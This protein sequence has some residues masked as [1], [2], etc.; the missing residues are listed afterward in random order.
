ME[1]SQI[2]A[3][4]NYLPHVL[5]P[6]FFPPSSSSSSSSHPSPHQLKISLKKLEGGQS[7]PTFLLTILRP[8]NTNTHTHKPNRL[9]LRKKPALVKVAS[10]HAIEREYRVLKALQ[11]SAV[12]VP[13]VYH[14]CED[15]DIIGM[16]VCM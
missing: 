2:T 15:A 14:L 9:V 10:A 4:E 1:P 16:Y 6:H 7:N 5:P 11:N 8:S 3:L 13:P 12:P